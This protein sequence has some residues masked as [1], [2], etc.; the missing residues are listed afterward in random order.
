[1]SLPSLVAA[2]WANDVPPSESTSATMATPIAGETRVSF[3]NTASSFVS[4]VRATA[5]TYSGLY[6]RRG[7]GR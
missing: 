4:A 6:R 5:P 2:P 3:E 1:M 7:G